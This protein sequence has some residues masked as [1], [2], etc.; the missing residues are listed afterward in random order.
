MGFVNWVKSI[1]FRRKL[2][3]LAIVLSSLFASNAY[4]RVS[5][6][7]KRLSKKLQ[8]VQQKYT[9]KDTK[10]DL[11]T[12]QKIEVYKL[13]VQLIKSLCKDINK[14]YLDGRHRDMDTE[15]GILMQLVENARSISEHGIE[16]SGETFSKDLA[17]V[18]LLVQRKEKG[19]HADLIEEGQK[20][21]TVKEKA[22]RQL[23]ERRLGR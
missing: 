5:P 9:T 8:T 15:V 16:Y 11:N 14:S 12:E 2:V 17:R 19:I 22:K 21:E 18:E 4:A 23:R 1:R 3:V 6:N 13:Y 20:K 7:T 10:K